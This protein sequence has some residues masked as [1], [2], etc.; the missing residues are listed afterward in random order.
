MR[1]PTGSLSSALTRQFRSWPITATR[2]TPESRRPRVESDAETVLRC[3]VAA[4][5]RGTPAQTLQRTRSVHSNRGPAVSA[6]ISFPFVHEPA[7]HGYEATLRRI[8]QRFWWPRVRVEVAAFIRAC[9]VCDRERVPNPAPRAPLGHLPA[10]QPF[11]A[12]YIDIV[13]GQN[14]LSLGASPK[15]I[16]TMID[17]LTDRPKPSDRRSNRSDCCTSS[18]P[19]VDR[20]IWRS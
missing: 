15:S 1:A 12:L 13:G 14:S 11:A 3:M 18:V 19:G 6:R 9:E 20:A 10:D 5:A 16:L 17:G 4:R 7:H 8:A 2:R